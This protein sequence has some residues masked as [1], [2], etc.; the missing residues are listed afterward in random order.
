M[1]GLLWEFSCCQLLSQDK[2]RCSIC[3]VVSYFIEFGYHS[4]RYSRKHP[5]VKDNVNDFKFDW[6]NVGEIY[7]YFL[8]LV[9]ISVMDNSNAWLQYLQYFNTCYVLRFRVTMLLKL[10]C[11]DK[12]GSYMDQIQPKRKRRGR[13][14]RGEKICLFCYNWLDELITKTDFYVTF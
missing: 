8:C 1:K 14:N 13:R 9:S 6:L 11:M 12:H 10:L 7:D 3:F 5:H 2:I 4:C